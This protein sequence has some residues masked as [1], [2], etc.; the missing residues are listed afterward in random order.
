MGYDPAE[1]GDRWAAVYDA[2]H[3]GLDPSMAVETLVT[4]APRGGR[5]LELGIGTGRLA[6]PLAGRGLQVHGVDA[7]ERMVEQLRGKPGGEAIPVTV[8]DF[9]DVRLDGAFDLVFVAFNTLFALPDQD[10]Q[11]RCVGNAAAHLA[12][13]GRFVVEAFVP[14]HGRFRDGQA[15]RADRVDDDG[16]RLSVEQH[17]AAR[18]TVTAV[19]VRLSDEG[20]RLLP[21]RLRYAWP[22]ELDLMA[23]LAGLR[24][25]HRWAGW[26]RSPYSADSRAHVS[27]YRSDTPAGLTAPGGA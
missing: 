2:E 9:A 24:L 5:V 22:S 26:G 3:E 15:V 16:A 23:R 11:V 7:S 14:D 21:V 25:E 1:Y 17:D 20:A 18:Q 8:A 4:L 10:S 12:P 27:V 19:V 6:L 13:G